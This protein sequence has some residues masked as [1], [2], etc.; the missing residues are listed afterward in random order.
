M[1]AIGMQ[2]SGLSKETMSGKLDVRVQGICYYSKKKKKNPT[3][4][5]GILLQIYHIHSI[6][7]TCTEKV[8]SVISI[9]ISAANLV[10]TYLGAKTREIFNWKYYF[11]KVNY[12]NIC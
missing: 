9:D 3:I 7:C 12:F 1:R 2:H 8:H 6:E 4:Q 11:A 10:P 5:S